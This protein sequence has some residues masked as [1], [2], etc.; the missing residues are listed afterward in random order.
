MGESPMFSGRLRREREA[1]KAAAAKPGDPLKAKP[2][3]VEPI[4]PEEKKEK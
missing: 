2:L 1:Q 4:R 3:A